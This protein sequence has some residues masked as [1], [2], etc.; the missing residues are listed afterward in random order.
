MKFDD[1]NDLRRDF[2]RFT[3]EALEANFKVVDFLKDLAARKG[4]TPAQIAL[5]WLLAQKPWIVPIPGGTKVEHVDD[6]LQA[7]E[8]ELTAGDLQ[9]IDQAFAT[10]DIKGAPLSEALDAAI[11]RGA[12]PT[13]TSEHEDSIMKTRKLGSLE[14]SEIGYGTMS[15]ASVYG[16]A[17]DKA[18]A[19]AVIRGA[20]DLGVTFFDTAEAYGPWTNEELVGEALKPIRDK[21]VIATKFGW[22]IDPE[23][24]VRAPASTA[25]P[26][27]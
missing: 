20:Y 13:R 9:E 25:G 2:P 16:T 11:D 23:T 17:P 5:A 10:I 8:M 6:N 1:P 15:F 22:N 7:A 21:V 12:S 19:I 27:M 3:P 26:R 24:G 4:I 18:E 14:V